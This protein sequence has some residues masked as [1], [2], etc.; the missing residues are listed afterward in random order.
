MYEMKQL[1]KLGALGKGA[2]AAME[3]FQALDNVAMGE[4][5]I[6]KKYK[7]LI[8]LAV[9]LTTQCPYCL[10][11]HKKH[12]VEAG[13]TEE[14]LAETTFIAAILRAGAAVVHGTHLM[15]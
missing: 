5:A 15:K 8:A 13:A 11:I 4:G 7:E 3:A 2:P 10:E 1:N 6:P 12:A 9:A 14:E